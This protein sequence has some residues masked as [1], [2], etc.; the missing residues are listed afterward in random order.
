MAEEEVRRQDAARLRK[1]KERNREQQL[2]DDAVADHLEAGRRR[3]MSANPFRLAF[4]K[5]ARDKIQ[6]KEDA[7]LPE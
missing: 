7:A 6:D 1:E 2:K 5:A 4:A 3:A